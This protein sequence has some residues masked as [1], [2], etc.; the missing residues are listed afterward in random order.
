MACL[1]R[2]GSHHPEVYAEACLWII[3]SLQFESMYADPAV[4]PRRAA[5]LLKILDDSLG[6]TDGNDGLRA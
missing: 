1:K 3:D 6:L 2:P 5:S 4:Y